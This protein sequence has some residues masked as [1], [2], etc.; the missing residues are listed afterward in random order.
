MK[1]QN[2]IRKKHMTNT[3]KQNPRLAKLIQQR[4][5]INARIRDAQS[6]Q[7]SQERKNDTRRKVI[8][9]AIALTH[10]EMHPH[11]NFAIELRRLLHQHVSKPKERDLLGLSPLHE[12]FSQ[13]HAS[14]DASSS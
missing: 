14:S 2:M 8:T 3:N 11:S 7:R 1:S 12:A 13:S 4:D 6:R 5:Q 10:M 9:G